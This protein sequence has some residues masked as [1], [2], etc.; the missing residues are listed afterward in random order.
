MK[1][2]DVKC[3]TCEG[4]MVSRKS[5]TGVFWGCKA[6]PK[7]RGTRNNMGEAPRP[8]VD[9]DDDAER[10]LPSDRWR[11]RDRRRWDA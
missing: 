4:P 6:F 9:R 1:P 5:A 8:R 11:D 10:E 7:C 2:E 3:P